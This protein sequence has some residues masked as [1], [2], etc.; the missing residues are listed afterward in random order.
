MEQERL[1]RR[2]Q[3][4]STAELLA[5]DARETRLLEIKLELDHIRKQRTLRDVSS[6]R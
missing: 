3:Y 4:H 5:R 6:D 1:H 2:K